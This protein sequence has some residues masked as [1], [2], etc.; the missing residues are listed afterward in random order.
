MMILNENGETKIQ[1]DDGN[2]S[3]DVCCVFDVYVWATKI[4]SSSFSFSCHEKNVARGFGYGYGFVGPFSL[5]ERLAP[6]PLA[7]KITVGQILFSL[8]LY[9]SFKKRF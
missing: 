2:V 5:P 4:F 8:S 3:Y 6:L 7:S 9:L 1:I